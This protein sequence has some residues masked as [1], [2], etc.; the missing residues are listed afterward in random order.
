MAVIRCFK[1]Y[2]VAQTAQPLIGT[3]STN[4]F[5][6]S[7]NAQSILVADSSMFLNSDTIDMVPAAGGAATELSVQIQVVD[8]THIKGVFNRN[9]LAGEYV[10]LNFPCMNIQVQAVNANPLTASTF[11]GTNRA[12]PTTA[13]VNAFYDLFLSLYY[14]G[15]P[16]FSNCDN[17]ANYWII[18]ASGTQYF[19]PSAVQ[20][21]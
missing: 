10:V 7:E 21:A 8:A 12:V 13:G 19:L 17:T 18:A 4:A 9:H 14:S 11:L 2:T 3:T 15:P 16:A 20:G 5:N 1:P 6:R